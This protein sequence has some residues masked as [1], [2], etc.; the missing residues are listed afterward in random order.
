MSIQGFWIDM[1]IRYFIDFTWTM[2][3]VI[4]WLGV[5]AVPLTRHS[6]ESAL[7]SGIIVANMTHSGVPSGFAH[8]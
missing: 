5:I 7:L 4:Q 2:L 3:A 6:R 1:G 8:G